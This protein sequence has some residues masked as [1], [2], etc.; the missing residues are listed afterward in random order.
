MLVQTFLATSLID[1]ALPQ[2]QDC[3]YSYRLWLTVTIMACSFTSSAFLS[4]IYDCLVLVEME[5]SS[6]CSVFLGL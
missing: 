4:T 1:L 5:V 2:L 6:S 3:G